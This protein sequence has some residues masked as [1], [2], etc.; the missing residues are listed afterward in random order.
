M[1][2]T[3][4]DTRM[5]DTLRSGF[6]DMPSPRFDEWCTRFPDAVSVLAHQPET[7]KFE[8]TLNGEFSRPRR[9]L[10]KVTVLSTLIIAGL[11]CVWL[12][13]PSSMV[14]LADS[15]PG[16]DGVETLTW[17]ATFYGR[18]TS[19]D[20]QRTWIQTT[21]RPMA[22][23]HPGLYRETFLDAEGRAQVVEITD[24]SANRKLVLNLKNKTATLKQT[25]NS[26]R[27][28]RG[29]FA[30][31]KEILREQKDR[32]HVTIR[33]VSLLGQK[34]LDQKAVNLV[35]AI[36]KHPGMDKDSRYD[37]F[38]DSDTRHFAGRWTPDEPDFELESANAPANF[39]EKDWSVE[40]GAGILS[41][42]LVTNPSLN[43][44]DFSL[45]PPAGFA[46]EKSVPATVNEDEMLAY[47]NAA[48][49]FN[50]NVFPNT[51]F[52]AFDRE[53]FNAL[54]FG[55]KNARTPDEQRMIDLHDKFLKREIYQP[56]V[57]RFIDDHAVP[58]SFQYVGAGATLGQ[59]DRI[60]CWYQLRGAT[61]FR[62]IYADLAVRDVD[63]A[64]LPLRL[65]QR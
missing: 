9:V 60:V 32:D 15:I 10:R 7:P 41:H 55:D 27:D 6:G 14:V 21:R 8:S 45:E 17:T 12:T 49:G 43:P 19:K 59:T 3:P 56:P 24:A 51:P 1:K 20:G 5:E 63:E 65:P 38:F 58:D 42:E 54:S 22:Y 31:V 46:F 64:S 40:I 18:V 44:S 23:R 35:R 48:V 36:V 16:I 26:E 61:N 57:R 47:L 53:R 37:F 39:P 4:D 33:S 2:T 11:I 50:N 25:M 30:W 28:V 29:P 34:Q 62:A 52:A 13:A